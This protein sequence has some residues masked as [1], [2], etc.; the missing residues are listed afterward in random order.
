MSLAG[1]RRFARPATDPTDPADGPARGDERCEV[2]AAT[3]GRRHGHLVAVDRR[4]LCCACRACYTLFTREGAGGGRFRAVPERYL[5][6]PAH[7]LTAADWD[8]LQVPVTP[9]FL[10]TNSALGR[11][12]AC[13]PSPA[14]ATECLLDQD[15]WERLRRRYPLFAA[16]APDVEAVYVTGL[17]AF[18]APIDACYALVGEVR[19]GWH[20]LD[21][22]EAVRRTL[23]RFLD[24]LRTRSRPIPRGM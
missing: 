9:A 4:S 5:T 24:D 18:L 13:Y 8:E 12:V 7:R 23:A 14:G 20:G 17:A 19:L 2:C 15:P 21:G 10:F 1:L 16:L 3:L 11:A 6:D 22:G